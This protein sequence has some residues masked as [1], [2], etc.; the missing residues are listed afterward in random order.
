MLPIRV[1]IYLTFG[2]V[3]KAWCLA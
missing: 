1:S 2:L 3:N